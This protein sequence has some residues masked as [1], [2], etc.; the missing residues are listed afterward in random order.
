LLRSDLQYPL[1]AAIV[2]ATDIDFL[3]KSRFDQHH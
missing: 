2:L 3:P 1:T